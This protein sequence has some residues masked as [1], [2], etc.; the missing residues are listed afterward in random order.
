MN[1]QEPSDLD[2][3]NEFAPEGIMV[4]RRSRRHPDDK[5]RT[6]YEYKMTDIYSNTRITTLLHH[7]DKNLRSFMEHT[8]TLMNEQGLEPVRLPR[9]HIVDMGEC[10]G[11]AGPSSVALIDLATKKCTV[12]VEREEPL[13]AVKA[14]WE[15]PLLRHAATVAVQS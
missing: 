9:N 2:E 11:D 5:R 12:H 6:L 14:F 3:L 15:H 8:L 10:C 7:C 1:A 13:E 4:S